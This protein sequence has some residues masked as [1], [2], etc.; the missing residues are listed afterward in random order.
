MEP[1]LTSPHIQCQAPR[2]YLPLPIL[3][4][5]LYPRPRSGHGHPPLTSPLTAHNTSGTTQFVQSAVATQPDLPPTTSHNG[6]LSYSPTH[7]NHQLL[8]ANANDPLPVKP[9]T[10]TLQED[11]LSGEPSTT[12]G[13][14]SP[15]WTN[16]NTTTEAASIFRMYMSTFYILYCSRID[17]NY[18][19]VHVQSGEAM[20]LVVNIVTCPI[21]SGL[22]PWLVYIHKQRVFEKKKKTYS[23]LGWCLHLQ[24]CMCQCVVA[25]GHK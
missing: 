15:H 10:P 22:H 14:T 21:A 12:S 5:K 23:F 19:F 20:R 7:Y 8:T 4:Y 3:Y 17:L 9:L 25:V 1:S 24:K 6:P 13:A 11:L 2:P 18:M 16:G